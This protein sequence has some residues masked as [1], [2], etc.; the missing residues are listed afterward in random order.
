MPS[1]SHRRHHTTLALP[2][3]LALRL[4]QPSPRQRALCCAAAL[5]LFAFVV[6][7]GAQPQAQEVMRVVWDKLAHA[8]LH[9]VLGGLFVLAFGL[10]HGVWAV[11]ACIGLAGLDEFAQ[12]FTPGRHVSADDVVASALGAT[13]AVVSARAF[14]WYVDRLVAR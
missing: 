13:L 1:N 4:R 7:W 3:R 11:A 10:R 9:Y 2:E 8:A 5:L 12:Q 14:T 6:W